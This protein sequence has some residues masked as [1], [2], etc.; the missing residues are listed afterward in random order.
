[1]WKNPNNTKKEKKFMTPL[2]DTSYF[3]NTRSVVTKNKF[4]AQITCYKL[5]NV[6]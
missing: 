3:L 5:T 2:K 4:E 6:F 1:M